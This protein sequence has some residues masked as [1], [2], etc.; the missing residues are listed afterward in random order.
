MR[1]IALSDE[2]LEGILRACRPLQPDA[3]ADFL[4]AVAEH[5]SRSRGRG[6]GRIPR[7]HRDAAEVFR[8]ATIDR[9][10]CA[11]QHRAAMRRGRRPTVGDKKWERPEPR[12]RVALPWL[13]FALAGPPLFA[14]SSSSLADVVRPIIPSESQ[15]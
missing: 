4:E 15:R 1:P 11:A 7:D 8:R 2:H 12:K 14:Q 10:A 5:L 9:G 13:S 3:R 6:R